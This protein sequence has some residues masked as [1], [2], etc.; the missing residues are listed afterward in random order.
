M[1]FPLSLK[2][3]LWLT[4]AGFI[5]FF[6]LKSPVEAATIL[7][8]LSRNLWDMFLEVAASFSEFLRALF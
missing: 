6:I 4:L 2:K 5:L 1:V 7:R 8:D 3:I